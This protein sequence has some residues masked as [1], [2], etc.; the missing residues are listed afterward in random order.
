MASKK[1]P[2]ETKQVRSDRQAQKLVRQGWELVGQSGGAL[3]TARTY[4]LRRPNPKYKG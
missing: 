2:F 1:E 3:M 4:T